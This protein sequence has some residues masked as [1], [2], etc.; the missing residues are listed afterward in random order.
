MLQ[1]INIIKLQR[2]ESSIEH[3][4]INNLDG[5]DLLLS[6]FISALQTYRVDNCLRPFPKRYYTEAGEKNIEKLV[7]INLIIISNLDR[8]K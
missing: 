3:A 6:L 8:F 5:C 7:C 2:M 4:F 1:T